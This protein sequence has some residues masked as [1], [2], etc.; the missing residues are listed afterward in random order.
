M[1]KRL[2]ITLSYC[3]FLCAFS[4]FSQMSRVDQNT[5]ARVPASSNPRGLGTLDASSDSSSAL[6]NSSGC[7]AA[8]K[9]GI[10]VKMKD[11]DGHEIL[12]FPLDSLRSNSRYGFVENYHEGIARIVKDQVYGYINVCGNKI[13]PFQYE[14]AE[15]FNK[16][17]ALVKKVDWYFMDANGNKS[18]PL[19]NVSD[20]KAL[21]K[22]YSL[23]TFKT[24]KQALIDNQYGET[25]RTIS[26][27]YDAIEPF[28]KTEIFKV[29][30]GNQYGLIDLSGTVKLAVGYD[31]IEP[32]NYP[33]L[34]SIESDN[35]MGLMDGNWSIVAKPVF[36]SIKNLNSMGVCTVKQGN[37]YRLLNVKTHKSSTVFDGISEFNAFGVA[38]I[39]D[40]PNIYGLI[41]SSMKVILEPSYYSIGSFNETGI[42]GACKSPNHCGFINSN[43]K[44]V[45]PAN[46][47]EISPFNKFGL[48]VVSEIISDCTSGN[49]KSHSVYGKNGKVIIPGNSDTLMNYRLTNNLHADRYIVVTA[50]NRDR[51]VGFH[52]IDVETNRLLNQAP[53][54]MIS[55]YD[56][57]GI[58][59]ISSTNLW[60]LMDTVGNVIL[61]CIYKDIKKVSEGF[62]AAKN[63]GDR[64]GF[65]DKNGDIQIPFE[66]EDVKLFKG[67]LAI[68][69]KGK[70]KWGLINRFN[71]KIIPCEFK[72]INIV[73]GNYEFHDDSNA[74]MVDANG[75][76]LKNC[77]KFEEIR[78][79]ANEETK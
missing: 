67:G 29:R 77:Q 30:E 75:E 4:G 22:G 5:I 32:S 33:N 42:A 66:Y 8:N 63:A 54:E 62:Y 35:K 70:N 51:P 31:K 37:G 3:F 52:L 56:I 69:S 1:F 40:G 57:N 9:R 58:F 71:A 45:F 50:L 55:S 41:D 72:S 13:G 36:D 2:K 44:E 27:S 65:I 34:Y 21:T 20:A 74:Y 16:G 61:P 6:I 19:A 12:A 76:C 38:V 43:G 39:K 73:G 64:F 24:G 18:V 23:V 59:R 48:T 25:K 60:G 28:Y 17:K 46:F 47:A 7:L 10:L 14:K 53:Y 79:R 49:C 15:P 68:V 78:K 11:Y 26:A